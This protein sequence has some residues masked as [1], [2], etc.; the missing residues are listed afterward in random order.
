MYRNRQTKEQQGKKNIY[1]AFLSDLKK[2]NTF[3]LAES[4][5]MIFNS[6]F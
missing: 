5:M 1:I 4:Q 6:W 2:Q 3:A